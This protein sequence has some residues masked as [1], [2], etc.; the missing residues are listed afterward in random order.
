MSEAP[1]LTDKVALVTGSSRNLGAAIVRA[2]ATR[3]AAVAIHY[4]KSRAAAEALRDEI[5]AAGGRAAIFAGD[6]SQS[7]EIRQMVQAVLDHYG[8]IDILVNNVGPYNDTAF[9]ELPESQWDMVMNANVKATY[10]CTQMVAP[11]MRERGWGRVINISAVS[12]F[13]RSHATYGL[14]KWCINYLTEALAVELAPHITVNAIAP[15]QI[16]DSTEIDEIDPNY[17]RILREDTPTRRLITRKEI[18]DFI[19]YLCSDAAS[20]ITGQIIAMDG[21]WSIPTWEYRVGLVET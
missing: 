6:A 2:L 3:G 8:A 1:F 18:A 21:G 17:K 15:G 20:N 11:G 5:L 13:I 16:E 12:A 19:L 10:L 4:H 7:H 9:T 14:A